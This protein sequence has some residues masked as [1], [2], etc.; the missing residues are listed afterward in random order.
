MS[1]SLGLQEEI[2]TLIGV[3]V[4]AQSHLSHNKMPDLTNFDTRIRELCQK[5]EAAPDETK[6]AIK[7]P[8]QTLLTGINSMGESMKMWKKRHEG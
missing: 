2:D 1:D 6:A 8:L 7:Q 5:I 4:A 3:L